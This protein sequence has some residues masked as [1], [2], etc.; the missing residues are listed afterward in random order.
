MFV[1]KK[2]WQ[3]LVARVNYLESKQKEN[4]ITSQEAAELIEKANKRYLWL[5]TEGGK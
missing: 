4:T 5:G 2:R 1:S 3:A